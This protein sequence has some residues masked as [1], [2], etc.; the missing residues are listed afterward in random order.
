VFKGDAAIIEG[1]DETQ[2]GQDSVDSFTGRA[3]L[4]RRSFA[5]RSRLS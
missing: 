3:A 2:Y 1:G 4:Y 5:D